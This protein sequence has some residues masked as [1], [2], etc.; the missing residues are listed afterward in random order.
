MQKHWIRS[1]HFKVVSLF[2]KCR[3]FRWSWLHSV[4]NKHNRTC[5]PFFILGRGGGWSLPRRDTHTGI[6]NNCLKSSSCNVQFN[7]PRIVFKI[8]TIGIQKKPCVCVWLLVRSSEVGVPFHYAHMPLKTDTRQKDKW[9]QKL[10]TCTDMMK[11]LRHAHRH[12]H[13]PHSVSVHILT[14]IIMTNQIK[15]CIQF[16]LFTL[17]H[18]IQ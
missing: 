6:L 1:F 18:V 8:T 5:S 7:V 2:T 14:P 13:W 9:R 3:A 17:P 12:A 11:T 10:Y 15:K 4:R 16:Y